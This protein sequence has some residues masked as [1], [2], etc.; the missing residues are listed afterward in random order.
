M[1]SSAGLVIGAKR[2]KAAKGVN[3]GKAACNCLAAMV[4]LLIGYRATYTWLPRTRCTHFN[5]THYRNEQIGDARR[6]IKRIRA[7]TV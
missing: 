5:I 4:L 7:H 3:N 2:W 6:S 1:L